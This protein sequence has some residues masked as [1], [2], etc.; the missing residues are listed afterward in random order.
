VPGVACFERVRFRGHRKS[1]R[2]LKRSLRVAVRVELAFTDCVATGDKFLLVRV[3]KILYGISR[4]NT[5]SCLVVLSAHFAIC[6]SRMRCSNGGRSMATVNSLDGAG[7][8]TI[9]SSQILR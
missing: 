3:N 7:Q 1:R 9:G 4:L 2:S 5:R 6:A 8:G